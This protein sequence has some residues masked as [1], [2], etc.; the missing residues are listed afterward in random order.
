MTHFHLILAPFAV[1]TSTLARRL[2][3]CWKVLRIE[4]A[5]LRPVELV[6]IHC[7]ENTKQREK[8]RVDGVKIT[9]YHFSEGSP[10]M[11]CSSQ[12]PLFPGGV[13]YNGAG[14]P[15]AAKKLL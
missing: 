12:V 6:A 7:E 3:L 14:L 4:R 2:R 5:W 10:Y 8:P 11:E 13:D 1:P 9:T 15:M